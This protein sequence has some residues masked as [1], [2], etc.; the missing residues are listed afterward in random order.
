MIQCWNKVVELSSCGARRL[1][2]ISGAHF[3]QLS[4]TRAQRVRLK[5]NNAHCYKYLLLPLL[6]DTLLSSHHL[7]YTAYIYRAEMNV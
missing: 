4:F 5:R 1:D 3:K 2:N 6:L 7:T